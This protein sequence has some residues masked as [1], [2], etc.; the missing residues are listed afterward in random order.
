M[1]SISSLVIQFTYVLQQIHTNLDPKMTISKYHQACFASILNALE[2]ASTKYERLVDD[3]SIESIHELSFN[4]EEHKEMSDAVDGI[5][6]RIYTRQ[7][8]NSASKIC[9][10]TERMT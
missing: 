3:T 9:G 2:F 8:P 7:H 1:L 6:K 5:M 4:H 10:V